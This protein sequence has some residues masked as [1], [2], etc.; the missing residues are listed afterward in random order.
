MDYEKEYKD[1]IKRAK[2]QLEEAKV[3]DYKEGQIAHNIRTTTYAI[4]PEL[5]ESE[6]EKIRK[7]II[8]HIQHCDDT[9]DEQ[10]EKRMVAWLEKQGELPHWKKSTLPNN[11]ATGFN[12]DYFIY[13]GYY[14]NYKELFN[15]LPKDNFENQGANSA[16]ITKGNYSVTNAKVVS[17]PTV[18]DSD[19]GKCT[20]ASTTFKPKFKVGDFIVNDY[21]MGRVVELTNDAYLLDTEQGIPF[22]GEHNVHLWTIQDA[23][24]GDIIYIKRYKDNSEWLLI[25]KEIKSQNTLIDVYDYYAYSITSNNTYHQGFCGLWGLLLDD[26]IVRPA[27]KEQCNLLFAKMKEEG[28]EWDAEKKDLKKISQEYPL[29]PDECIKSAWNDEDERIYYSLLADIRTRQDGSTNT[30]EAYYNEQ[31][32]WLKSL[33]EKLKRE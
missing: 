1:A 11:N 17:H 30:L 9:I 32:D 7:E 22:S 29:T 20:T 25:F 31:I 27:T 15:K 16:T 13:N 18:I 8:Y 2:E 10:T 23:N 26:E 14:I 24:D 3:F 19:G 6:N 4:F 5:A 12:S 28:F 33:K 21:C